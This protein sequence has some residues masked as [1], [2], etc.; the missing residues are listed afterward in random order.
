MSSLSSSDQDKLSEYEVICFLKRGSFAKVSKVRHKTTGRIY[1][2]KELDYG[3][4][5][6]K[7]KQ[8]LVDEVNILRELS[9]PNI[10]RYYDRIIDHHN[11]KIF[12]VQEHCD[13]GDLSQVIKDYRKK[14]QNIPESLIWSVLSETATALYAC[15]RKQDGG[16]VLH[17]DLK[18]GNIFLISLDEG[19]ARYSVK[20]GDF[21]LA[22]VLH[23]AS[24]FAQTHVGT[25]YYMSPEQIQH[26][27]YDEKSDIWALGCIVYEMATLQPP[28]QASGYMQL[29][30]KIQRG[31]YNHMQNMKDSIYSAEL[32]QLVSTMLKVN[33]DHRPSIEQILYIPKV[34]ITMK[35]VMAERRYHH[36]KKLELGLK[37]K[38]KKLRAW[39]VKL[40]QKQKQ[41]QE[42]HRKLI[43]KK[44][45]IEI[46]Q[47][48]LIRFE[49]KLRS[50][51]QAHGL[52]FDSQLESALANSGNSLA[53][54]EEELT[55]NNQ[56]L[57]NTFINNG[58]GTN[59][60]SSNAQSTPFSVGPPSVGGRSS[61][62]SSN[63]SQCN[64]RRSSKDQLPGGGVRT[65]SFSRTSSKG[66]LSS[67]S[68]SS[69]QSSIS[70]SALFP[71]TQ[72]N[73][74]VRENS[75]YN[76]NDLR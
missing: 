26:E 3:Q 49:R 45:D 37:Q 50:H 15:H 56:N 27:Q 10:V 22:R 55:N 33:R 43:E 11:R 24:I 68:Q 7:E 57:S 41:M 4:M 60:G 64:S 70:D 40:N 20:L 19:R 28:F 58:L 39:S 51:A 74:L 69:V 42:D 52:A 32:Q 75:V 62:G 73:L 13:A 76:F 31:D 8:M 12:I 53:R 48:Q 6:D 21:G 9:H 54:I 47:M 23:D 67:K 30:R 44:L 18:P 14:K 5:T 38:E 59:S 35:K 71:S 25:P 63:Q 61:G 16:R 1:V 46:H 36:A 65:Q 2:W 29:A 17:R 72:R 66:S 34:Q